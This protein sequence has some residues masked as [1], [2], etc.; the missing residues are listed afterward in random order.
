MVGYREHPETPALC[1]KSKQY[2]RQLEYH[3]CLGHAILKVRQLKLTIVEIRI[4]LPKQVHEPDDILPEE[5]L[6]RAWLAHVFD[7]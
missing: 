1:W 4:A 2:W 5:R 3:Q 7:V 6:E